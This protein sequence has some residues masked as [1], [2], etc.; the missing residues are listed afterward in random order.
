MTSS[1][2]TRADPEANNGDQA[3]SVSESSED[4]KGPSQAEIL[5]DIANENELFHSP[6]STAYADVIVQGHRETW[7]VR[8]RGFRRWLCRRFY[9]RT[10]RAPTSDALK[11]VLNLAEATAQFDGPE[12]Y[13]NVR[14]AGFDDRLYLDL[15]DSAWRVVEMA[16]EGWRVVAD[17]PVRFRRSSGMLPLPDPV[18]GGSIEMLRQYINVRNEAEFVL[19]VAWL[20][21]ALETEARIQ[22]SCCRANKDRPSL[23]SPL[24]CDLWWTRTPR[25]FELCLAKIAIFSSRRVT[26]TYWPSTMFLACLHG[27]PTRSAD[28]QLAEGSQCDNFTRTKTRC[29]LMLRDRWS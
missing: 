22:Y 25:L 15:A 18:P 6:D 7:P 21:A 26:L 10:K 2:I 23:P 5:S 27:S 17:S 13:V 1:V 29:Y 12:R 20:L 16:A 28:S 4:V 14:V 11:S 3:A 8:S 19:A 9:E 24:C